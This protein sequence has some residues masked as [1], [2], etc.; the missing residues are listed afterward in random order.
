MLR[1]ITLLMAAGL[2]CWAALATAQEEAP[3]AQAE[4]T[5]PFEDLGSPESEANPNA[6][7]IRETFGDWALRCIRAADNSDQCQL[8]QLLLGPDGTPI[9]EVSILPLL[10]GGNAAAGVVVVVP[11]ETQLTEQLTL[12]VDGSEG[13]RYDFDFCNVA[14][15]VARFGLTAEQVAQFKAGIAGT[16]EIVPAAAP[17]Q[18]IELTMGL[19]GFT[20]GYTTMEEELS[21][22]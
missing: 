17:D 3:A 10:N 19:S 14:G 18:R 8:Y 13:R 7:F 4:E 6:P 2:T 11:L 9:S 20:A 15:C 1:P 5:S 21:G 12:R 22:E 16:M